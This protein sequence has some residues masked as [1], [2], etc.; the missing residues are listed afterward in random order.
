MEVGTFLQPAVAGKLS[1]DYVEARL[2]LDGQDKLAPEV[3]RRNQALKDQYSQ[4][5]AM[6][7]FVVVEPGSRQA[8][9]RTRGA[10]GA[11]AFLTF[12]AEAEAKLSGPHGRK[13]GN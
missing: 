1:E 6:P 2:H 5:V 12:L 8:L 10:M 9:G 11:E 13:K 3:D 7:T 4:S